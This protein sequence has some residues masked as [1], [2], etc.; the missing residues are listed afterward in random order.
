MEFGLGTLKIEARSHGCLFIYAY[1][2]FSIPVVL[3]WCIEA[4]FFGVIVAI[5]NI[6]L[7]FITICD[8]FLFRCYVFKRKHS[9]FN[10]IKINS[11]PIVE[12]AIIRT[13]SRVL[14]LFYDN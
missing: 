1:A 10:V 14:G 6:H 9:S 5:E 8:G 7:L 11:P 13:F 2:G 12:V 4:I 3:S